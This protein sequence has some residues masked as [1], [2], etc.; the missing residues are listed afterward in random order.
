MSKPDEGLRGLVERHERDLGVMQTEMRGLAGQVSSLVSVVDKL[1]MAVQD[2]R[3][4]SSRTNWSQIAAWA[5]VIFVVVAGLYREVSLETE[6]TVAKTILPIVSQ[7]AA[8]EARY[9]ALAS[10]FDRSSDQ[11]RANSEQIA[12]LRETVAQ[13]CA[14]FE[15]QLRGVEGLSNSHITEVFRWI[16]VLYPKANGGTLIPPGLTLPT[17]S[18]QDH[19]SK[20]AAGR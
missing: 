8:E 6:L 4:A 14:N 12:T 13:N 5:S 19:C 1:A 17:I 7:Y 2:G 16:G 15:D 20:P 18:G 9:D 3:L 10:R 11:V